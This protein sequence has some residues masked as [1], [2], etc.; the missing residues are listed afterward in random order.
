MPIRKVS[1]CRKRVSRILRDLHKRG[2]KGVAWLVDPDKF[3]DFQYG[4]RRYDWIKDSELDL[5]L[6][7]GSHLR[8]DNFKDVVS[9]IKGFAGDI[10]VV[11]FPGAQV[12]LD[13][14]ADAVLFLSLISGRNPEYLIGQQVLAA[15]IVAAMDIEVLPTAYLLVNDGERSSVQF[16][17]QTIPLPNND[18]SVASSTA[19]AGKFLGMKFFFLD[20]GSGVKSP[21]S[22]H[23]ISAVKAA[24]N[25]PLL[26]GGGIDSC[27]KMI[28]SYN[29]G[30]DLIVIGNAIEKAPAFLAEALKLKSLFN[31]SL[32]VN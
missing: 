32:H 24:V 20:A 2:R 3:F 19:L 14:G 31:L 21:V 17:S 22:P 27:D 28:T 15:P 12:Q 29:A 23:V 1:K 8:Q 6:V 7:G 18:P 5:I 11:I 10:P 25:R 4:D 26:V 13:E 9:C 30:A 16:I